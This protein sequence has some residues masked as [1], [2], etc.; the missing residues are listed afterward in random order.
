MILKRRKVKYIKSTLITNEPCFLMKE[1]KKYRKD[2]LD[3]AAKQLKA[4][5]LNKTE[6]LN[7]EKELFTNI[8]TETLGLG[9]LV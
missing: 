7:A 8:K 4:K 3:F 9:I 5:N 2:S 6:I 1:G